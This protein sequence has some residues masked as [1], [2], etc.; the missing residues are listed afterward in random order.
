MLYDLSGHYIGNY[1]LQ[2]LV[3][4]GGMAHIYRAIDHSNRGR[5][6]AVK[7]LGG[8]SATDD[9]YQERF[10]REAETVS[11]L[12][13][14]NILPVLDYGREHDLLYM[15]MP[16]VEGGTLA[17]ALRRGR[18]LTPHQMIVIA[19]QVA[20]ALDYAHQHG[21]IHRDIKP[22]NIMLMGEGHICVADFGLLKLSEETTDLTITGGVLGTPSYMS[23][24]QARGAKLDHRTDVYSFGIVL[25][26]ALIGRLPFN[27]NSPMEMINQQASAVPFAPTQIS[28]KFPVQVELVLLK[29]LLKDPDARYQSAGELLEALKEAVAA[30]PQDMRHR[31]LVSREEIDASNTLM[32]QAVTQLALPQPTIVQMLG[33]PRMRGFL[34]V[35][36]LLLIAS[37]ALLVAQPLRLRATSAEA[38]AQYLAGQEPLVVTQVVTNEA[39]EQV[40][41]AVTHVVVHAMTQVMTPGDE[42]LNGTSM[43]TRTPR[44]TLAASGGVVILPTSKPPTATPISS[45]GGSTG[46]SS[47]GSSGGTTGGSEPPAPTPKPPKTPLPPTSTPVP[48]TATIRPTETP[49]PAPTDTPEPPTPVPPTPEPPTSEPPTSEPPTSEPP[50]T[51]PDPGATGGGFSTGDTRAENGSENLALGSLAGSALLVGGVVFQRRRRPR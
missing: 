32:N 24:E 9:E 5:L 39:G 38:T 23:P 49:L 37:F 13:H 3:A 16:L 45:G 43:P 31:R 42:Q 36:I 15:V 8:P 6:V 47:G 2:S 29:A 1:E 34:L 51:A 40:V 44:P 27:A 30:L 35:G 33:N 50:T 20:D 12:D 4:T 25:Y 46:G 17:H 10:R 28:A 48:P 11:Q 21:V 41:I 26:E 22:H 19:Q 18:I 14:A 7:V